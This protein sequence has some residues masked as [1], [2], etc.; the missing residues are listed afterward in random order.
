VSEH[1]GHLP[2]DLQD[3]ANRLS[4]ARATPSALELDELR[5][6]VH[7]RAARRG[8]AP[9]RSL[10]A[11]LRRNTLVAALTGALVLFSGVGVVIAS[12]SFGGHGGDS[13]S[14][15][16]HGGDNN[17][18]QTTSLHGDNNASFCQYH[19]PGEHRYRFR[20][21]HGWVD[22]DVVWDCRHFHFHFDFAP[23]RGFRYGGF[24]YRFGNG[25]SYGSKDQ[26]YDTTADP[27]TPSVTVD[28]DGSQFTVPLTS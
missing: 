23:D 4:A 5:R 16:S 26:S 27:G 18:F 7:G 6:R 11:A 8:S 13:H 22:V 20:T 15:D 10:A 3:I 17:V 1:D 14:G 9:R 25:P 28:C 21:R 2:E 24:D 19:G 12:E